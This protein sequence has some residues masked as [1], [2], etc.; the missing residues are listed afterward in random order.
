MNLRASRLR[1]RSD[2]AAAA[3][4]GEEI[5]SSGCARMGLLGSI[6]VYEKKMAVIVLDYN[7]L[8][9]QRRWHLP[10]SN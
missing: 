2:R 10:N 8:L 5:P 7:P 6:E 9:G 3:C 4:D 1:R